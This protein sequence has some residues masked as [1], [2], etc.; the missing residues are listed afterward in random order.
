MKKKQQKQQK[1]NYIKKFIAMVIFISVTAQINIFI[2]DSIKD[3]R[4][5]QKIKKEAAL[6]PPDICT[7]TD[8]E[9][10]M[11]ELPDIEILDID[12]KPIK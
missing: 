1:N 6:C 9:Y 4:H 2:A 5:Q 10:S 7:Y 3:Y 8:D 11:S 12:V